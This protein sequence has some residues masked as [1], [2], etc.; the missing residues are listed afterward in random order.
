MQISL[1]SFGAL[2]LP[3]PLPLV[4]TASPPLPMSLV[5]GLGR[6]G[7][8]MSRMP[9]PACAP[10]A[11]LLAE[12]PSAQVHHAA[13]VAPYRSHPCGWTTARCRR[14]S[15][16]PLFFALLPRIFG[17]ADPLPILHA[18]S[19]LHHATA[20]APPLP[21]NRARPPLNRPLT[22]DDEPRELSNRP[23][24]SSSAPPSSAVPSNCRA[25]PPRLRLHSPP[26]AHRDEC[27]RGASAGSGTRSPSLP[28]LPP[29]PCG[30]LMPLRREERQFCISSLLKGSLSSHFASSIGGIP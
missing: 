1:H 8:S 28:P 2:H 26:A 20:T 7:R 11:S 4:Q 24:S 16:L 15:S 27:T 6:V 19:S 25:P 10:P 5:A 23:P 14:Q 9:P 30:R 13:P 18:R 3:S 17:G 21:L 12:P 29:S 22:H